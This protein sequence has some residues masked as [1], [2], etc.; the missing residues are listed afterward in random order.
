MGF[1]AAIL[2]VFQNGL[3]FRGRAC[4]AE[5]WYFV[6]FNWAMTTGTNILSGHSQAGKSGLNFDQTLTAYDIIVIVPFFAVATRRLHDTGRSGWWQ[7]LDLPVYLAITGF[8]IHSLQQPQNAIGPVLGLLIASAILGQFAM[9]FLFSLPGE[10]KSN[11][12]GPN[13]LS[14]PVRISS[15]SALVHT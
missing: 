11:A 9:I 12:Y 14:A 2:S 5:Y 13:P 1:R 8:V 15:H 6:L 3:N 4:R 10:Q 7:L